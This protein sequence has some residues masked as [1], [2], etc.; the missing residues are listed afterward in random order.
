[1]DSWCLLRTVSSCS[2]SQFRPPCSGTCMLTTSLPQQTANATSWP[3]YGVQGY[4]IRDLL[5]FYT[6]FGNCQADSWICCPGLAR[7]PLR[8]AIR[9]SGG[10]P[11]LLTEDHLRGRVIPAC[12]V[13][14]WSAHTVRQE[15]QFVQNLCTGLPGKPWLGPLVPRQAG[16]LQQL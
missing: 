14:H 7:R 9:Q 16:W 5:R 3:S 13:A 15:S 2:V 4:T 11:A 6:T 1:M 12:T 10:R 8:Q